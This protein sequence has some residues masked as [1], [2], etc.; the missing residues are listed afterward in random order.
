MPADTTSLLNAGRRR[1][2][3]SWFVLGHFGRSAIMDIH[4]LAMEN[5]MRNG[6]TWQRGIQH[7]RGE[8]NN[9]A[10][11][12]ERDVRAIRHSGLM[13]TP[14]LAYIFGVSLNTIRRVRRGQTWSHVV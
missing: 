5:S 12:E 8:K 6:T 14:Q 4:L 7:Q 2:F 1:E 10:K 9:A 13:S 3:L 11:L